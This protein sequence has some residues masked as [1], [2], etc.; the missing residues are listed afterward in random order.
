[1]ARRQ[2][3]AKRPKP[4]TI[5]RLPDLERR[6]MQSG[7]D[8]CARPVEQRRTSGGNTA[9]PSRRQHWACAESLGFLHTNLEQGL[10]F[11]AL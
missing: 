3:T 5:L 9:T 1:M 7:G 8:T 4:K 11:A 10:L 2:K 6:K